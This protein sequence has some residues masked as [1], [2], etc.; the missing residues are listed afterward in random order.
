MIIRYHKKVFRSSKRKKFRIVFFVSILISFLAIAPQLILKSR[1]SNEAQAKI[2]HYL[3]RPDK[4]VLRT[5]VKSFG[6][7]GRI[8]KPISDTSPGAF[9]LISHRMLFPT[10]NFL[11][12][13]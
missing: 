1:F 5:Y 8:G 12:C 13:V 11:N 6:I 4:A 3:G 10:I 7:A 2:G 9:L